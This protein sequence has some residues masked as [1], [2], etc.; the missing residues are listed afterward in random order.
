MLVFKKCNLY[1]IAIMCLHLVAFALSK[2]ADESILVIGG[3]LRGIP[4]VKLNPPRRGKLKNSIL[5][6]KL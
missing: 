2:T 5:N 3:D 6:I 4:L 1:L